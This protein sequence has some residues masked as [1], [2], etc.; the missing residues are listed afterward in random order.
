MRK[1]IAYLLCFLV[2]VVS[3]QAQ[4]RTISGKVRSPT[5]EPLQGVNVL[6]KGTNTGTITNSDG[7]Y[8]IKVPA[9]NG[10]LIFSYVGFKTEEVETGN[11]S[12]LNFE[13]KADLIN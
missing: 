6:V 1:S 8:T 11:A 9:R 13:M 2:S 12:S 5:K 3:L 10:T 7:D 4:T